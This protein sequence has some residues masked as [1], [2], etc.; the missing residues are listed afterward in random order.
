MGAFREGSN[1]V[2]ISYKG[3]ME[4]WKKIT[5]EMKVHLQELQQIQ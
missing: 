3:T 1:L 5:L 2:K 4:D